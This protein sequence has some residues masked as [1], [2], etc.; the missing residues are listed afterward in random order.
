MS[1]F[2]EKLLFDLATLDTEL[3]LLAVLIVCTI[4]VLDS[5][6]LFAKKQKQEAGIQGKQF[7][8]SIEGS[9]TL[10]VKK[11]ISDIQRLSGRPDALIIEKGEII[12]VERKPLGRKIRDRYVAQLLVYMRLVE[13]F[14]GKKPPYGYLVLG[15]KC[16]QVKIYNTDERQEWLQKI[17]DDMHKALDEGE[18]KAVAAPHPQKCKKCKVRRHCDERADRS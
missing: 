5:V 4:I 2:L 9:K 3:V 8:F 7:T 10:P 11:Y 14:E 15:K 6:S 12:P 13:E 16:R 17:L 1:S 18:E